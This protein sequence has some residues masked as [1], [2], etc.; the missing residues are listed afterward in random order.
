ME[1][2][3]LTDSRQSG[4]QHDAV[5]AVGPVAHPTERDADSAVAID[6]FQPSFPR[7]TGLLPVPSPPQGALCNEPSMLTLGSRAR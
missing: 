7:S 3:S 6:H 5:V 1:E 2:A 4:G